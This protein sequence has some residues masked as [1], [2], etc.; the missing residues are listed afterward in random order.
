[1]RIFIQLD[2]IYVPNLPILEPIL[3][4]LMGMIAAEP[5]HWIDIQHRF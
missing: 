5:A 4:D 3:L 2:D 1:M